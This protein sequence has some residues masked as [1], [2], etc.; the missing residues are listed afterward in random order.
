MFARG[1]KLD[2]PSNHSPDEKFIVCGKD[3][4]TIRS[5]RDQKKRLPENFDFADGFMRARAGFKVE[6]TFVTVFDGDSKLFINK[7]ADDSGNLAAACNMRRNLIKKCTFLLIISLAFAF[8]DT[9][10][11]GQEVGG[12]APSGIASLVSFG[13]PGTRH[14]LCP[15]GGHGR[16]S[17]P[18]VIVQH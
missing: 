7:I 3:I 17:T 15:F 4:N 16:R 1:V 6:Q 10:R 9:V 14:G 18:L 12:T 11:A 5:V 8:A 2:V 13:W